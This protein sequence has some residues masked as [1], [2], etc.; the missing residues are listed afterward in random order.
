MEYV[1]ASPCLLYT[2]GMVVFVIL[3]IINFV[4]ITNGAGRVAEVGARFTLDAMP[5]KQ[6]AI[7]ADLNSGLIDEE[8]ARARRAEIASEADFYGAMDGGS[9]FVKGD[10]IAGIVITIV[11][12]IAGFIIGIKAFPAAGL[13]GIGSLP[14]A[15]LGGLVLGV[16]EAQFSGMV[17]T[18]YKDVF[19]FSLLVLILIFRPQGLL[20]R[21]QIA[22]V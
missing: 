8:T 13:G 10:A 18:D 20:G 12:L 5:G 16:A 15:R 9:K 14:G 3:V 1:N 17:N 22:K 19:A 11:N 4:V 21:P 6:M 2:S 7:D